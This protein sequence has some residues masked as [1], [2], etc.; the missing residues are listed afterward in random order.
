MEHALKP[1]NCTALISF[2]ISHHPTPPT[3]PTLSSTSEPSS[4]QACT[5]AQRRT[6]GALGSQ[7]GWA[8]IW[9]TS[10]GRDSTQSLRLL[11]LVALCPPL[12]HILPPLPSCIPLCR[13]KWPRHGHHPLPPPAS[14]TLSHGLKGTEGWG[15]TLLCLAQAP[16]APCLT[17]LQLL[18]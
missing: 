1:L 8:G 6:N 13:P 17:H 2:P 7:R 10:E 5:R 9:G 14:Q 4:V 16:P 3:L 12:D 15:G 18:E 11:L